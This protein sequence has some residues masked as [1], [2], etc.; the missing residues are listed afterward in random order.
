MNFRYFYLFLVFSIVFIGTTTASETYTFV[1]KWG[2]YGS[3]DGQFRWPWGV[4]VDSSGNVFVADG[5]DD[6]VGRLNNRIQKFTSTGLFLGKWGSNGTGDGE[7]QTAVG[8]TVDLSGNVF[9]ADFANHR[10]QKFNSNGTFL[11]KWGSVGHDNGEFYYPYDVAADSFGN[12]YVADP[13]NAR[14]QKFRSNGAFLASWGTEDGQFFPAGVAVD[15]AGYIYATDC[16]HHRILKFNSSGAFITEWGSEGSGNGQFKNPYGVAVDLSDNIYVVD[17]DNYRIQKFNSTGAFITKWGSEGSGDGWFGEPKNIA[18]DSSGNVYVS[19]G[20]SRIQKFAPS[21][22]NDP[23]VAN[24][25]GSPTSGTAPLTVTF[26]DNSDNTPTSW[27]WYFGDGNSSTLPN[28]IH[29]Y[30]SVGNYTV[31]LTATNAAGSNTL[32]R[33]E[34][35]SVNSI[36]VADFS[37]LP[38]KIRIE[39]I[40]IF[41]AINTTSIYPIS[42]YDWDFGDQ[43][44]SS[45]ESPFSF[46]SYSKPGSYTVKLTVYDSEGSS[47]S[48]S[49]VVKVTIPVI[50]VHGFGDNAIGCWGKFAS[51]LQGEGYQVYNFDYSDVSGFTDPREPAKWLKSD[52]G[53]LRRDLTYNGQEYTGKYDLVCHSIGALVSRWYMEELGG[54]KDIRQWI[55][56]APVNHG[57]AFADFDSFS[58]GI[59]HFLINKLD[60]NSIYF[61]KTDSPVVVGLDENVEHGNPCPEVKY[62]VIMGYNGYP[63]NSAFFLGGLFGGRTWEKE[64]FPILGTNY[65]LTYLGDGIV[66]NRQSFLEF[67]GLDYLDGYDHF[68]TNSDT[69]INL[70]S[71]YIANQDLPSSNNAPSADD[72]NA[73]EFGTSDVLELARNTNKVLKFLIEDGAEKAGV[74]II[75]PGSDV[76]MTL[77]SPSGHRYT[78]QLSSDYEFSKT[79]QSIFFHI[80]SP[81]PGEWSAEIEPLD[82]SDEGEPLIFSTFFNSSISFTR[83]DHGRYE[84]IV[85]DSLPIKVLL[86][87]N[88]IPMSDAEVN[89]TI[90]LPDEIIS[91][92]PL[93]DK[94]MTGDEAA[95]DGIYSAYYPLQQPGPYTVVVSTNGTTLKTFQRTVVLTAFVAIQPVAEFSGSPRS[96]AVPLTVVFSDLSDGAD[97]T[98]W[99][100]DFDNNGVIDSD[101]PSPRYTYKNQGNFTVSLTVSGFAGSNTSK[102]SVFIQTFLIAPVANFIVTPSYGSAP[103]NV[104]FNDTST[105]NPGMWNWSFGDGSWFN[106][107]NPLERNVTHRYVVSGYYATTLIAGNGDGT[108]EANSTI[109]V[110]PTITAIMPS[111]HVHGGKAFVATLTGTGFQQGAEGTKMT[112]WRIAESKNITTTKVTATSA[113][114]ITSSFKIPKS[115]KPGLYNV[116]VIYPDG[117]KATLMNKFKIKT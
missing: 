46:H 59:I 85:G 68:M 15:S 72:S 20:Y 54:G 74:D 114:K 76:N 39:D 83:I 47:S 57:A 73:L 103:L 107:T 19:D 18:V 84:F 24:F 63:H 95:N 25:V 6:V 82:I 104:L 98:S 41:N 10:I 32:T 81:E 53:I 13:F 108:T 78:P 55:G 28:P 71:N 60:K 2:S 96:G 43:E 17:M 94:G 70:V 40:V 117:L 48:C 4:A 67:A 79:N 35:I 58:P 106:T 23:P 42:R 31:S 110:L 101:N 14:I 52:I 105:G 12:V 8:I 99:A 27:R 77:V 97:I 45:E 5:Y 93:N 44:S 7:F 89:A 34:Y 21:F 9:V 36:P 38:D 116:S 64:T 56:V 75:W 88:G 92:V 113:L 51:K 29:T 37:Y 16:T 61:L 1:T 102:K 49:Q 80:N 22:S 50:F 86:T 112:L 109:R 91:I 69:V 66:A 3:G 33:T 115:T 100:W 90:T 62:R 111:K 65:Y 30:S 26:M 11:D 87:E